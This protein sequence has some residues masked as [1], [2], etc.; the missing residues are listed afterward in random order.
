[1]IGRINVKKILFVCTGN[2]CRSCM[3]EALFR[4]NINKN[5]SDRNIEVMSA[6]IYA[7]E[8]DPASHHALE[9]MNDYGVDLSAHRAKQLKKEMIESANL[10]LTMTE[11]HRRNVILL[12]PELKDKIFTINEYAYQ[13][14]IQKSKN[15]IVDP[16]GKNKE[17]YTKCAKE[18][19][20]ALKRVLE[21]IINI[22]NW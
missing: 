18:L 3:A 6:G 5:Y 20:E 11:G 15:D 22:E 1:M 16:Y 19:E 7:Y 17:E 8:G 2:T 10:I 14:D 12:H 4:D 13:D 21:R 9:T